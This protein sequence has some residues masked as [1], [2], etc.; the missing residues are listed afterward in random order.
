M[1]HQQVVKSFSDFVREL[2]QE[3]MSIGGDGGQ[4]LAGIN[5]GDIPPVY[6]GDQ[7]PAMFRRNR[8]SGIRR[9]P[10]VR[11]EAWKEDINEAKEDGSLMMNIPVFVRALE[12]AREKIKTDDELHVFVEK[13]MD[14][15]NQ[16]SPLTM[17]DVEE[18]Y[19]QYKKD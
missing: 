12:I 10:R 6:P 3:D 11:V 8:P 13:I 14:L 15:Q 9:M 17:D 5:P 16:D 4:G 19:N 2:Y 7:R 1:V 18:V